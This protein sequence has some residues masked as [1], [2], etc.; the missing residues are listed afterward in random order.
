MCI[1]RNTLFRFKHSCFFI[2]SRLVYFIL[3]VY[4]TDGRI[5][6][7]TMSWVKKT[8]SYLFTTTSVAFSYVVLKSFKLSKKIVRLFFALHRHEATVI[9]LTLTTRGNFSREQRKQQLDWL[10][11]N[12]DDITTQSLLCLAWSRE[13]NVLC[14]ENGF[15]LNS[16][17]HCILY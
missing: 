6:L 14:K 8:F 17:V 1:L 11:T 3:V 7:K 9:Q 13:I 16:G 2:K 5:Y 10:A 4:C 15:Y 12:A